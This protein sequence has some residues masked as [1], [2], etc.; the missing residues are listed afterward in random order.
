M[1]AFVEDILTRIQDL[2][3]L[4]PPVCIDTGRM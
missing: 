1:T 3:E 2:L 4:A